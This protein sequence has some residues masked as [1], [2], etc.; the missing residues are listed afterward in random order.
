MKVTIVYRGDRKGFRGY[1]MKD[2][3]GEKTAERGGGRGFV[4]TQPLP[5]RPRLAPGPIRGKGARERWM[6]RSPFR[7]ALAWGFL[8]VHPRRAAA[9][10][11]PGRLRP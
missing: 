6:G 2:A 9:L 8:I 1:L 4:S 5:E 3:R 11:A 10:R 7:K